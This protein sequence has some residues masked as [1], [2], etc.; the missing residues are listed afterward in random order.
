[1]RS[2][3]KSDF[4][5]LVDYITDEQDKT[6]RL[7]QVRVTNCKAGTVQAAIDEVLATQH[8]NTR[9]KGDK[10]YHLLVGFPPGETP[11]A[12][13]LK[14]IE[15]RVCVVLGYCDHQ[16]ISAV[17]H[18]TDNLHIHIAINKIHP[19]K[20]TMHE[21]FLAYRT[22]GEVCTKL[23]KE[24]GLQRINH[25]PRRSL[26]ENRAG[27][28][29]QHSGIESLVGWIK[30]ECLDEIRSATSWA[31]LHQ[32]MRDN[33]LALRERANGIVIEASDGTMVK[34]STVARE[35]SK[36]KLEARLG[37]FGASP[38]RQAQQ[39]A[40]RQ[41]KKNPMPL[42]V[43]TVE[44]YAKYKADQAALT[45]SRATALE[46]AR[47]QKNRKVEAVKQS[48][49]LRRAA[50]K[51]MGGTAFTKKLLYAQAH[52]SLLDGI[53]TANAQYQRERQKLL[54]AHTRRTWADWLKKEALQGNTEALAAL[55]SR[56]AAQSLKGNTF[57]GEGTARTGPG[58]PV[59]NITK[60]GTIIFRAGMGA[61]RDDGDKLQISREANSECL[62]AA[63][64]L[65]AERYGNRIT[66]NG[67][68][69][70][71]AQIVL[72]AAR[73][74]LP[75]V[76][77]DVG[78]ESRRQALLRK[79]R[80]H[81][82]PD[83]G[84]DDRR[85]TGLAGSSAVANDNAARATNAHRDGGRRDGPIDASRNLNKPNIGRIGRVPPPQS[86][87][88]LRTLSKLGV[89]RIARRSE[90]LLPGHVPGHMEQQGTKRVNALRRGV[91]GPGIKPEQ[92]TAADKYIAEREDKRLKGFDIPNHYRYNDGKGGAL[93]FAGTRN[94]E[95][96]P[97][98]LLKREED[99]AIMVMPIDQATARRLKRIAVGDS[100]SITPRGSIKT[101]KGI[102]R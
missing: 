42:R 8:I 45:S 84:R 46:A 38:E 22:L 87:N 65:A 77:A 44:L 1:M 70:F 92:V 99:S 24:Y 50:I 11:S 49:R 19:T 47:N 26:S 35:L 14:A 74:N 43:N 102:S 20:N 36:P 10:T 21:P 17:H 32:V 28:M 83:R 13:V 61:V 88:R 33:G 68:A 79:E 72:A 39:S 53:G 34:A 57:R 89:V 2:L 48:N 6:Q 4:A 91:S 64:R 85:S 12:E 55:R 40:K 58:L 95:G 15:E 100:V 23:E 101:S 62:Q 97:L 60:K 59:D 82:Q 54:D 31:E 81:E 66:V 78:L 86:K 51:L 93:K 7:G 98:A 94:I 52:K 69:E 63:L 16:R 75:I 30:R 76:F 73:S 3:G 41:Y 90:V 71:K 56:E 37:P 27:D 67:T 9:A 18:D 5:G 80:S 25:E 96:Q 29:E